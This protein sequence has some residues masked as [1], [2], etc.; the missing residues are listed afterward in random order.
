MTEK[1]ITRADLI[2]ALVKEVSLSRQDCGAVL[3]MVLGLIETKLVAGETVKLARFGNF[4]V[5]SKRER[6]GRNPKTGV[7]ASI[8]PRRVVTFK[9][10]QLLRERVADAQKQLEPVR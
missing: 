4:T 2:D 10:S 8:A 9:P 3:E 5:R 1:T 7:E 6:V